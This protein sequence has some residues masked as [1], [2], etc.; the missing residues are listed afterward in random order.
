[1]TGARELL[2][3]YVATAPSDAAVGL[4]A[5]EADEAA[6]VLAAL[7][8]T[9]A[10]RLLQEM[11]F[12]AAGRA[13]AALEPGCLNDVC[14]ELPIALL[15][16]LVRRLGDGGPSVMERLDDRLAEPLRRLLQYPPDTAGAVM[17]PF[18]TA[19][20]ASAPAGDVRATLRRETG[21]PAEYVYAVAPDQTLAGVVD[22]AALFEAEAQAPVASLTRP[23]IDWVRVEMPLAAVEAHPGWQQYDVLPVVDHDKRLVDRIRHRRL[24]QLDRDGIVGRP[25]EHAVRTLVALGEV[26]WLGL[27]GLIQGLAAAATTTARPGR[28]AP[29]NS[30]EAR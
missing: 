26:Y 16:N 24:R 5:L 6:E 1:M 14:R 8:P 22:V 28:T 12:A 13:L 11:S 30:E 29:G 17:D 4:S 25:D 2:E 7:V 23:S 20:Q 10:A 27:S 9:A 3:E 18:V 21:R 15:A 19:V